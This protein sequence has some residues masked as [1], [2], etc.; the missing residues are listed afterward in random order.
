MFTD[1]IATGPVTPTMS[2]GCPAN[3]ANSTP[4]MDVATRTSIAPISSFVS[5]ANNSENVIAGP[6]EV[7]KM[8]SVADRTFQLNASVQSDK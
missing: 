7:K 8:K 4:V 3:T 2:S 6:M 1:K 5:S